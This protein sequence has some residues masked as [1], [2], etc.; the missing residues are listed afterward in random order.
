MVRG[1]TTYVKTLPSIR[2]S[3]RCY[4]SV[5]SHTYT[6]IH[7]YKQ[8]V[9]KY[10]FLLLL[11]SYHPY[12]TSL[13]TKSFRKVR[14]V[15]FSLI[16]TMKTLEYK[17]ILNLRRVQRGVKWRLS[18]VTPSRHR[19]F[20]KIMYVT[21]SVSGGVYLFPVWRLGL[22]CHNNYFGCRFINKT[23]DYTWFSE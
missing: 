5:I 19:R 14:K 2:R 3:S 8:H 10:L 4:N 12:P 23:H 1:G 11:H 6:H 17:E 21:S 7:V 22:H 15:W 20:P 9:P 16:F 18:L 13:Q